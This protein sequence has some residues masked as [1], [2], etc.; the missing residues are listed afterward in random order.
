MVS[1]VIPA[2]DRADLLEITLESLSNQI[3]IEFEVI[4]VD[5]NS[6]GETIHDVCKKFDDVI[7][8]KNETNMGAQ[9]SRNK[10]VEHSKYDYIA[11]LDSD[12]IW[13][14]PEKLLHQ[15][16]VLR[17]KH[18][19]SIVFTSIIYVDENNIE[20]K[21]EELPPSEEDIYY[22]NFRELVLKK[23]ILGTYSSVMVR[24][25]DFIKVGMCNIELR[26]RQDWDL[27]I[28]LGQI[29]NAYK[30][31]KTYTRYRIHDN[32]ISSGTNKK[33]DGYSI[34][35]KNHKQLFMN[36]NCRP[37]F[38]IHMFKLILLKEFSN[39]SSENY[40]ILLAQNTPLSTFITI[41]VTII[42]NTPII[43]DMVIKR[44]S[45]AYLFKGVFKKN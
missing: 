15:Y 20:K 27:W 3:N 1:V 44:L 2:Y 22:D 30:L 7:Y 4:V 17:D 8:L 42:K 28:R 34:L 41:F 26:A 32:Q 14:T 35:L 45:K 16:E 12:D 31:V 36:N 37:N 5:D 18:D 40:D 24:K 13:E 11:F 25:E 10:G 19:V 21:R 39:D 9:V 38:Y 29:G 43:N 33:L 6:E 23:D